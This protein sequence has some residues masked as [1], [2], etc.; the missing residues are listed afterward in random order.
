MRQTRPIAD[1]AEEPT[2]SDEDLSTAT[3]L[4]EPA[5][6]SDYINVR[7]EEEEA[8][9]YNYAAGATFMVSP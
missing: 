7:D 8:F 3:A 6:E 1:A 4:S 9:L 5:A 2:H